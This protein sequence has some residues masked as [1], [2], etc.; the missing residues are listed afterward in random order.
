MYLRLTIVVLD[1]EENFIQYLDSELIQIT[2][3]HEKYQL[4]SIHSEY[5]V[6]GL[7]DYKTLFKLGNKLWVSSDGNISDCL[8]V[9]NTEVENDLF[10]KNNVVFDAEEKLVELN[11]IFFSQTSL[12]EENSYFD[13]N[14]NTVQINYTSLNDFFGKYFQIGIIQDCLSDYLKNISIKGTMSL[15]E[16]LRLIEEETGNVF[17]PR[18][19]KETTSNKIRCSLDFLNP[20]S[21]TKKWELHLFYS[22]PTDEIDEDSIAVISESE[23]IHEAEDIVYFPEYVSETPLVPS[24]LTF[25]LRYDENILYEENAETLGFNAEVDN[26]EFLLKCINNTTSIQVNNESSVDMVHSSIKNGTVFEI[27]DTI[28]RKVVYDYT[29]QPYL[30]ETHEEILDLGFNA[31]NIIYDVNEEDTF[32]A[33]APIINH[34]DLEYGQLNDVIDKWEKL[35]ILTKDEPIPMIIQKRTVTGDDNHPCY[36]LEKAKEILGEFD[37]GNNYYSRPVKPNDSETPP[38]TETPYP[39]NSYEFFVGTAYWYPPFLKLEDELYVVDD[40]ITGVEYTH[41]RGVKDNV[42]NDS[43]TSTP[44]T[45]SVETSDEDPYAIYNDVAMKLKDKRYPE[46]NVNVDVANLINGKFN[47][48]NIFDKV[49]VK[50][51]GFQKLITAT[52]NK[53]EKNP[54]DMGENKVELT[55]YSVNKKVAPKK[56]EIESAGISFSYPSSEILSAK[57]INSEYN[58]EDNESIEFISKR[59]LTFAVYSV[60]NESQTITGNI[61]TKKTDDNGLASINLKLDPGKYS[62]EII[63]GGDVEYASTTTSVDVTVGG[64]KEIQPKSTAKKTTTIREAKKVKRYYSSYGVSPNKD[65]DKLAAIGK[66]STGDK[67]KDKVYYITIFKRKCPDCGSTKLYWSIFWAKDKKGNIDENKSSGKFPATGKTVKGSN[68]GRVYCAKCGHSWNAK[69][70]SLSNGKK[71][72]VHKKSSTTTKTKAYELK[73]G[74]KVYDTVI[75]NVKVEKMLGNDGSEMDRGV[76]NTGKQYSGIIS[77]K[78]KEK[79]KNIVKN[80]TGIPAAKKIAKWVGKH[81]KHETRAGL[82]QSPVRT[83]D[84]QK[85]NCLCQTDLF[86]QM[87]DAVGVTEK[88]ELYYVWVGGEKFGKRH[89][90]AKINGKY[91]DVDAKPNNPWGHASFGKRTIRTTSKYPKLPL[92]R[93]YT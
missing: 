74:N 39:N 53:T 11:N 14:K 76:S 79:A 61:Y 82:Y 28:S 77:K 37:L 90:F 58:S 92:N 46:I 5:Y 26:N 25:R 80:S 55:N 66:L 88:Y 1:N 57:L 52:V 67:K 23:D 30:G 18:Y 15:M 63:F 70:E 31:E 69:G 72:K 87:C 85:G 33:I 59:V 78:V 40:D 35:E 56:T 10:E 44:K 19:E 86:F 75:K 48:Y 51:P 36:S 84:R 24:E 16:L 27:Y 83:L 2:E 45:G 73:N 32:I 91:V 4:R 6:E 41:I 13:V 81:I 17:V 89:F 62:V 12:T 43:I 71:L 54:L 9:L 7:D 49:Y 60:E 47:E 8:Y 42:T 3:T 64:Q 93:K 34:D 38:T 65:H 21:V 22:F 29:L 68:K 50:I 20:K